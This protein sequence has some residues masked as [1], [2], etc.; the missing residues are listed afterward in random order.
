MRA[1]AKAYGDEPL[2]RVVTGVTPH[3]AYLVNPSTVSSTGIEA[4]TGVGFPR[5]CVY[6]FDRAL[7]DSLS[8]AWQEHNP[9]KLESLWRQAEP[10]DA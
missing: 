7:F 4:N 1:L 5:D 10:L 3:V 6:R 9:L 2:E 8:A